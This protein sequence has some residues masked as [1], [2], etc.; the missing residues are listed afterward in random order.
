MVGFCVVLC[1]FTFGGM[2]QFVIYLPK[3]TLNYCSS[4]MEREICCARVKQSQMLSHKADHS[5]E[6]C[7][8]I[9]TKYVVS[10]LPV[11]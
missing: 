9:E 3:L 4:T 8:N 2:Q 10:L 7:L 5:L 11:C 1:S 6:T